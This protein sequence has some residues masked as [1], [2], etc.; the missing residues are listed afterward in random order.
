[1]SRFKAKMMQQIR[2]FNCVLAQLYCPNSL[3]TKGWPKKVSHY[4]YR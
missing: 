2:L 4:S 1:M 3:H